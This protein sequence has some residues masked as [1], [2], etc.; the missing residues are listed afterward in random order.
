VS[1]SRAQVRQEANTPPTVLTVTAF[2]S[3]ERV[4][5]TAP[6]SIV[7]MRLEVYDAAGRKLF[8][9]EL[10]GGN[11]LDWHLQ[12]GQAARLPSDTYLCVVTVKSRSG[13]LTQRLGAVLIEQNS[14]SLQ[15]ATAGQLTAQ[16]AAAIGP[17]E[18]HATLSVIKED[19][20][21]TPTVLA[22]NGAE[23]QLVRGR[24]A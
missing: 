10:R 22:H 5:F 11:V 23:G 2:A 6:A 12:D 16:Q 19:E 21:Q 13:R 9:N 7:Q 1:A 4:R 8:D 15:A 24:G 14:V 3:S 20:T 18:E 17:V